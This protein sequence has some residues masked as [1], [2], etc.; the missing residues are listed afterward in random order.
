MAGSEKGGG[1]GTLEACKGCALGLANS[2]SEEEDDDDDDNEN[3]T[4]T[5]VGNARVLCLPRSAAV[6][7]VLRR[8]EV[9]VRLTAPCRGTGGGAAA[10]SD[11]AADGGAGA[12]WWWST[13]QHSR[14]YNA[15]GCR[16]RTRHGESTSRM[17]YDH[18]SSSG[19]RR[20][21]SSSMSRAWRSTMANAPEGRPDGVDN[22]T[23]CHQDVVL[24]EWATER[25]SHRGAGAAAG[26]AW[27]A[28]APAP[29]PAPAPTSTS[30]GSD[31]D[32][33]RN[34][35]TNKPSPVARAKKYGTRNGNGDENDTRDG[36]GN[37]GRT[38]YEKWQHMAATSSDEGSGPTQ[39]VSAS[40]EGH[41]VTKKLRCSRGCTVG[42]SHPDTAVG[43]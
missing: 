7:D 8:T 12:D 4:G 35:T 30:P 14:R 23:V 17:S 38:P 28:L 15:C 41:N 3:A 21:S 31:V 10:V 19:S 16:S 18:T 27:D 32:T 2:S 36:R 42:G 22:R 43:D 33:A 13:T 26:W 25:D 24:L 9:Y 34:R 29:A 6:S 40:A 39:S 20:F 1:E 37:G 5:R 11:A